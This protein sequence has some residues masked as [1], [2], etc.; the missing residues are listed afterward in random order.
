VLIFSHP[1]GNKNV[2]EA[3]R[4]L[5]ESGLLAE[6]W[7]SVC[8]NPEHP[9]NKILPNRI[10]RE[11][12]RRAFPH[13]RR[14]QLHLSPWRE[15]GRLLA[16]RLG[17]SRLVRHESGM[18]SVDAVYRGFDAKVAERLQ[19]VANAD[20]VYAYEDGA[21]ATFRAA[22]RLG[23][24][25][26]YELP[27]GYWRAYRELIE[28]EAALRPEWAATLQGCNDSAEKLRRKDEELALASHIVVPSSF[29]K[30]TLS[31]A[32]PLDAEISV[33][34]YGA[35]AI[36]PREAG[37]R[38]SDK[39]KIIFVGSLTQRKG[40]SYLLEAVDLLGSRAELTLVGLRAAQ[41]KPL[42]RALRKHCW[43]PS[44]PHSELL[45][46]IRRH[47]V[48][49]FPSL[50]EGFGLVI[51]EAMANGLPVITTPNTGAPDFL[52]DGHDGF[53]VPVRDAEAIAE[54]LELL[55]RDRERLDAMSQAAMQKAALRSWKYYRR[56]LVS[57]VQQA[58]A[59]PV[60]APLSV[61]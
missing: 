39:L 30:Q 17:L 56:D 4:A 22:K 59:E 52:S 40:I 45:E 23:I 34:P 43:I 12:N 9:V 21:L 31:K 18:F 14:D 24:K 13:V 61:S 2:R 41:C 19:H 15:S 20:G 16:S 7:T 44:L 28:E 50:F 10:T 36:H 60:D 11:L 5:N 25:T 47:D 53:I 37:H 58:L 1:I 3:A 26:I 32:G 8:W 54:K 48:M 57:T 6:F 38:R 35:P 42:D 49:V 55:S 51:L 46:E 27:I 29:V 33:V